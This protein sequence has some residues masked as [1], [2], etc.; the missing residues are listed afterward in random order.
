MIIL[1]SRE[2][3]QSLLLYLLKPTGMAIV[4]Y[5]DYV[6]IFLLL[7]YWQPLAFNRYA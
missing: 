3:A 6:F 2:L 4:L 7:G 5:L 1:G